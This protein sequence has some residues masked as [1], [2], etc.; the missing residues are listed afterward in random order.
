MQE[1]FKGLAGPH[2]GTL[3]EPAALERPAGAAVPPGAPSSARA[4]LDHAVAITSMRLGPAGPALRRGEPGCCPAGPRPGLAEHQPLPAER[5]DAHPLAGRPRAFGGAAGWRPAVRRCGGC[6]STRAAAELVQL[7]RADPEAVR[8]VAE[9]LLQE[10]YRA[11]A[12]PGSLAAAAARPGPAR[13]GLRP[14]PGPRR[15]AAPARGCP[16]GRRADHP[17]PGPRPGGPLIAE[18]AGDPLPPG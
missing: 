4:R 9:Q 2:R 17:R 8:P 14:R 16:A 18:A 1:W 10:A 11:G 12:R 6:C 15:A 7:L 3:A 5:S 13:P